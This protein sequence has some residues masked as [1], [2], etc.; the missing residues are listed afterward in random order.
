MNKTPQKFK[1]IL[2]AFLVPLFL[3][4][5]PPAVMHTQSAEWEYDHCSMSNTAFQ[6]GEE[7]TYKVYYNLNFVWVPAGEVTFRVEDYGHQ[8]YLNAE[9]RTYSSYNWFFEVEDSYHSYVDKQTLL[10]T[11]SI[12]DVQEGGYTL[13]E[14]NN[15]DQR[16][17][18]AHTIRGRSKEK[19]KENKVFQLDNCMHDI[20]SIIYYTRNVDANQLKPGD[21]IPIEVFM[22]KEVWPLNMKFMEREKG[23]K[24]KGLGSFNTL[25]L[26]PE[27]IS[28][29][30]FEE[31]TEM[32]IYV[33]DDQNKIPLLIESPVS[34]GSV[35][36]VLKDYKGLRYPLTAEVK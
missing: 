18:T 19:I 21:K 31:G 16:N 14:K 30:V 13:Y 2:V 28:G 34:V 33:S 29:D 10:P 22:D 20:L 27:V 5:T 9:G 17:H 23:T 6:G 12:R 24:I 4:F 36:A 1:L 26:S 7:V 11:V 25:R 32:S 15:F 8:Y 3:S 35:K